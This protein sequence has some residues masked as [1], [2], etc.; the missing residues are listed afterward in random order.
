MDSLIIM[1]TNYPKVRT[2]PRIS[3]IIE[4]PLEVKDTERQATKNNKPSATES[5]FYQQCGEPRV[6][7]NVRRII[8]KNALNTRAKW[9]QKHQAGKSPKKEEKDKRNIQIV[10]T[11]SIA[12]DSKALTSNKVG[13]SKGL[14]VRKVT[15][16]FRSAKSTNA[17][18]ATITPVHLSKSA[19]DETG[20][21]KFSRTVAHSISRKLNVQDTKPRRSNLTQENT[22]GN[23]L[24]TV[25]SPSVETTSLER[26][27]SMQSSLSIP[28][29]KSAEIDPS[30][31]PSPEKR[32]VR[33]SPTKQFLASPPTGLRSSQTLKD[34]PDLDKKYIWMGAHGNL[35]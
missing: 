11:Q 34:F 16:K 30:I 1:S 2:L 10:G 22:L 27:N 7:V 32:L 12:K 18:T 31:T 35:N 24:R 25:F 20:M 21:L 33:L 3:V 23:K 19:K 4:E 28:E 9:I 29:P 13:A 5:S 15:I 14:E 17:A 8:I 26:Y 6:S